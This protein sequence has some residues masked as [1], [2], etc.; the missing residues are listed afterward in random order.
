MSHLTGLKIF[1]LILGL[2]YSFTLGTLSCQSVPDDVPE[3]DRSKAKDLR[4]RYHPMDVK[5]KEREDFWYK[6]FGV[7][8]T[9]KEAEKYLSTPQEERWLLFHEKFMVFQRLENMLQSIDGELKPV[10]LERY[11]KFRNINAAREYLKKWAESQ[12]GKENS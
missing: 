12:R 6:R 11:R 1:G 10:K 2:S 9:R 3:L 7:Y 8:M 5:W 4:Y